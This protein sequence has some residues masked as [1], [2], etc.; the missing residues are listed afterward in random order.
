MFLCV[1]QDLPCYSS[2]LGC[3]HSIY[4]HTIKLVQYASLIIKSI[5]DVWLFN[6]LMS[7]SFLSQ[8]FKKFFFP[9]PDIKTF[10]GADLGFRPRVQCRLANNPYDTDIFNT[11]KKIRY[12]TKHHKDN[13]RYRDIN[14]LDSSFST[15]YSLNSPRDH[16]KQPL[17]QVAQVNTYI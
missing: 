13:Y 6:I 16:P 11:C 10:V 12:H 9:G 14:F 8:S 2:L 5:L 1:A 4:R 7:H 15:N 17:I 3:V